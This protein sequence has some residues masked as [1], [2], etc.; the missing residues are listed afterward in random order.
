MTRRTWLPLSAALALVVFVLDLRLQPGGETVTRAVDD[1]AQLIAAAT[2]SVMCGIRAVRASG[3]LRASWLL[4]AL[5]TGGW[6]AGETIWSYY[7]LIAQRPTPF[8]SLAD[9]GYLSFPLC[10]GIGIGVRSV[11]AFTGR[12]W[13]RVTMD[14]L[15]IVVSLLSLSWVTTLGEIYRDGADSRLGMIVALAYPAGDVALLTVVLVVIA[16]ASVGDRWGLWWLGAGLVSF[17]IADS[18]FAFLTA[19]GS[20]STGNLIDAGWV[21]GFLVVACGALLDRATA[22]NATTSI[23]LTPRSAC[24]C[25][26]CRP[27]WAS[28]RRCGGCAAPATIHWPSSWPRSRS[29]CC[30]SARSWCCW[31]TVRC[32]SRCHIKLAMMC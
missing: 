18:G 12:G 17:A 27:E 2:C 10:T 32:S 7:E 11:R 3:R 14:V 30:W 20:Y 21:G 24:C 5:G 25:R 9:V 31:R 16:Y 8:P 15:L 4:L 1:L 26:I 22:E 6:A 13:A 29:G 19:T 28:A 23:S